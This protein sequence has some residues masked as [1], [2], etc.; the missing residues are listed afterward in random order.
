LP[1]MVVDAFTWNLI[2]LST[3]VISKIGAC[4]RA[5]EANAVEATTQKIANFMP[6]SVSRFLFVVNSAI[7]HVIWIVSRLPIFK[8]PSTGHNLL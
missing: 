6:R 4:P 7:P 1:A 8:L 2:Q 5:C 3:G